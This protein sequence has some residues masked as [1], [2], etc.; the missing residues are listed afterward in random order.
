MTFDHRVVA[1][2]DEPVALR[3]LP[4]SGQ[5]AVSVDGRLHGILDPGDWIGVFR[6]PH[7]VRLIRLHP[8]DF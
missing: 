4:N 1:A 3:I 7:R 5:A 8:T 6:A 2:P